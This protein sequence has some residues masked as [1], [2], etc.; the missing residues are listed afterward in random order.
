MM[1]SYLLIQSR[2]SFGSTEA[3]FCQGL[4][5]GLAAK[6][7]RVT[8]FLVQNGVLPARKGA[9]ATGLTAL[10]EAGI[11]VLAD[12]FSLRERGLAADRLQPGINASPFDTVIDRLAEGCK[13]IWH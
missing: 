11:E 13:A 6:G 2:D 8:L 7:N 12:E 10:A 4:A 1:T 3:E 5:R 9:R